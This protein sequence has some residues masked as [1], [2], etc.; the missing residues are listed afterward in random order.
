LNSLEHNYFIH[1]FQIDRPFNIKKI[2]FIDLWI[3]LKKI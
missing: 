1:P 2:K 3:Y